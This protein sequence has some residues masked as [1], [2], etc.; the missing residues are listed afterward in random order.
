MD[1]NEFIDK[2]RKNRIA[3]YGIGYFAMRFYRILIKKNLSDN[4]I[5]FI[6]TEGKSKV[7]GYEVLSVDDYRI[8]DNILILIAV[9][10]SIKDNIIRNLEL[11]GHKNHIWINSEMLY[12]FI[13]GEPIKQ[14]VRVPIKKIWLANRDNFSMAVRYL[15][16]DNYYGKN[17]NGYAIYKDLFSMF[18]TP[19]TS[20]SRLRQ[21]IE[22][23]KSWEKNGYKRENVS[24][25]LDDFSYVDGTH[26]ISLASYF[27][28]EYVECNIYSSKC[29][30]ELI[31]S[32]ISMLPKLLIY[33]MN[34]D[35][36]IINILEETN[37][38]IDKQY[39]I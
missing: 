6:T 31:H 37:R 14:N 11:Y 10:E 2:I 32:K 23:I 36:K 25:I 26:R 29:D 4:L 19:Q 8:D 22:L 5:F 3:I 9:H 30:K 35:E 17:V 39:G 12:R 20:E 7:E 1:T 15:V 18:N 38:R 16:V 27:N 28:L 34:I 24:S 21:F 33:E 13:L